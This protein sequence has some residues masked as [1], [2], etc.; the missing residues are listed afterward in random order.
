MGFAVLGLFHGAIE[1]GKLNRAQ[2]K[3]LKKHIPFE[4]MSSMSCFFKDGWLTMW[5]SLWFPRAGVFYRDARHERV[6]EE[7]RWMDDV[8][9]I[10]C[11]LHAA[12]KAARQSPG[13][14][15]QR[16]P[17]CCGIWQVRA[18]IQILLY[19]HI[20]H[21]TQFHQNTFSNILSYFVCVYVSYSPM[22]ILNRHN[23]VWYMVEGEP[24]C[25]TSS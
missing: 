22:K 10:Q 23:E 1:P 15:Q 9:D 13:H 2:L 17:L 3:Y 14:L 18:R 12:E 8:F 5:M 11:K 7:L 21:L 19:T 16:L 25:P 20:Q 6:R 4:P 24:V